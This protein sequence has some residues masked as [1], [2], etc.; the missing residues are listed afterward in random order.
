MTDGSHHNYTF[1]MNDISAGGMSITTD[2]EIIDENALAISLDISQILLPH[3]TQ[4]KGA[5]VR[6]TSDQSVYNYG[7]RFFDV[8]SMQIIEIDEYLRFRHFSSLVHVV[9]NPTENLYMR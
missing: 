4:L 2:K 9:E 6:K 1:V 5:V 7:I 8:T 3:M